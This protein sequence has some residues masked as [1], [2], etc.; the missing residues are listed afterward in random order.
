MS[1]YPTVQLSADD[2]A[3]DVRKLIEVQSRSSA[4]AVFQCGSQSFEVHFPTCEGALN[5]ASKIVSAIKKAV[6]S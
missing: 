3:E 6:S 5:T 1:D 2:T 4:G